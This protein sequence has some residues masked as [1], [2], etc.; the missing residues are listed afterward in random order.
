[1]YGGRAKMRERNPAALTHSY[2]TLFSFF[3]RNPPP[4]FMQDAPVKQRYASWKTRAG[5]EEKQND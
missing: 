1:M 2:H 3:R 5:E 4:A